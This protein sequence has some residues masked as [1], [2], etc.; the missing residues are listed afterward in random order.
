MLA[1]SSCVAVWQY[2]INCSLLAARLW[3]R[4]GLAHRH[5]AVGV[6]RARNGGTNMHRIFGR[7]AFFV[8]NVM[9]VDIPLIVYATEDAPRLPYHPSVEVLLP[10]AL[11]PHRKCS[12]CGPR[13]NSLSSSS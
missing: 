5:G 1:C 4:N 12:K 6:L 7:V 8:N 11:L 10:D 13:P 3:E 9:E 2:L